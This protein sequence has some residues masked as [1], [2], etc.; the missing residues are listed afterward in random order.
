MTVLKKTVDLTPGQSKVAGFTFTPSEAGVYQVLVNGLT[1][2]FVAISAPVGVLV[3][4]VY[5]GATFFTE[6]QLIGHMETNHPGKPYLI[7]L[8]APSWMQESTPKQKIT[9]GV[10]GKGFMPNTLPDYDL[11]ICTYIYSEWGAARLYRT[12]YE[13]SG[14]H[15]F[16]SSGVIMGYGVTQ[17]GY[18][19]VPAGIYSIMSLCYITTYDGQNYERSFAWKDADTGLTI[20]VVEA[21]PPEPNI[22]VTKIQQIEPSEIYVGDT[23]SIMIIATNSG[24]VT[25][26]KEIVCNINSTTLTQEITLDPGQYKGFYFYFVPEEAK[27]YVIQ[28]DGVWGSF[29]V[30]PGCI[31][32]P[33]GIILETEWSLINGPTVWHPFT[34]PIPYHADYYQQ[35]RIR[36]TGACDNNFRIAYWSDFGSQYIFSSRVR[37][38]AGG[39]DYIEK[40]FWAGASP[41]TYTTTW[42]LFGDSE[43]VDEITV[44]GTIV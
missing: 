30:L 29:N 28:V 18:Y 19:Y 14:A 25:G 2:N 21:P 24:E 40:V 16:E 9:V 10:S 20:E 27:N 15:F 11:S 3:P 41:G 4:C 22:E 35:W 26:S 32:P 7:S 36:N 33:S 38:V 8:A 42:Y 13:A 6:A 34:D 31:A 37:I 43:I 44:T 5:C 17:S 23:V 1:G 39:E 12:G